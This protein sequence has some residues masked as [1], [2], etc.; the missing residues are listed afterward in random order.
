MESKKYWQWLALCV[1]AC[2]LCCG[3]LAQEK[4]AELEKNQEKKPAP[5]PG[6]GTGQIKTDCLWHSPS[7]PG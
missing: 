5:V 4:A 6:T 3:A 7:F 2:S 1:V